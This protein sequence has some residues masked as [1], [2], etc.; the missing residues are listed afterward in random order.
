[1]SSE[2]WVLAE[3][4]KTTHKTTSNQHT[5][6]DGCVDVTEVRTNFS[7]RPKALK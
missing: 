2:L 4:Y 6:R 1:M 3:A 7:L 5:H